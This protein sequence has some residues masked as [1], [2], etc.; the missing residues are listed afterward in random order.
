MP[1]IVVHHAMGDEVLSKLELKIASVIDYDI[2]RFSVM[3]PD[4]YICY[5]FFAPR[6]R[7]GINKR[8]A[9][10][11]KTKTGR[12]LMELAVNSQ[13]RE[14]FSFLAGFL[15]HYALDSTTHPFINN[16]ADY[17]GYMHIAI[18]HRLD[19]M[20]LERQGKQRRD[21]MKLFTTYPDLP[22][23]EAAIQNIYGWDDDCYKTGY[24]HMKLYHWLVKDQYGM[25]LFILEH[26][27]RLVRHAARSYQTHL[28]DNID[29]SPFDEL[30]DEAVELA[31]SMIT[32]AYRFRAGEV[33]EEEL[34][35]IIGNR[36]YSGGEAA[37]L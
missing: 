16:S 12:F 8:S 7:H 14:M 26:S 35:A 34:S 15:C 24:R 37:L 11:H 20:E 5:R 25:L 3:G 19:V 22:E 27:K 17:K 2:F 4:P 32:A 18:E 21:L 1:D 33:S 6:L 13:S 28:A 31:V 9:I 29:L 23:A 30:K 36:S 10:M